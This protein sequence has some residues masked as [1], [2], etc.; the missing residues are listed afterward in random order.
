MHPDHVF[1]SEPRGQ[2]VGQHAP[3]VPSQDVDARAGVIF[4]VDVDRELLD[5]VAQ[6]RSHGLGPPSKTPRAAEEF[7]REE[8]R[9]FIGGTLR[10]TR[11][12]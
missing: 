6:G 2:K 12:L 10:G 7:H 4:V 9:H 5:P 8:A 1:L 11:S 3:V